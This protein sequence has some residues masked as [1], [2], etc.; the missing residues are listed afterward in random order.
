VAVESTA[1][2]AKKAGQG[3]GALGVL[4]N[5]KKMAD[6]LKAL[7]ANLRKS[8]VLFYK[9]RAAQGEATPRAKRR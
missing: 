5:D 6:D 1:A 4:I 8:G 7:A 9:D 2:L 3:D